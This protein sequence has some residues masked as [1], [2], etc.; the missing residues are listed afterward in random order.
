MF[1]LETDRLLDATRS[2]FADLC[3]TVGVGKWVDLDLDPETATAATAANAEAEEYVLD[4]ADDAGALARLGASLDRAETVVAYNG[5]G[6]DFRVLERYFGAARVQ[7]WLAKLR[8]P[9]EVIR[10]RTGSW[11]KLDDLLLA[12]GLEGKTADG[13]SAVAWWGEGQRARVLEY[14]REDVEALCRLVRMQEIR[15]PI[16]RWEGA[17]AA[18]AHAVVGWETLRWGR[19]LRA[20]RAS[21]VIPAR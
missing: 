16:K 20:A 10:A 2:N 8:D 7:G 13:L 17:G 12:N 9:F 3:M 4:G 18:R 5:R 19:I 1:D 6:F 11:V 14:C 21:M 15:F